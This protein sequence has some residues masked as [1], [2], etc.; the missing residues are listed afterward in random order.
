[1]NNY[2]AEKTTIFSK[3]ATWLAMP[4]TVE[5]LYAGCLA[6]DWLK[7]CAL[8]QINKFA[9]SLKMLLIG[10]GQY[11]RCKVCSTMIARGFSI[12]GSVMRFRADKGGVVVITFFDTYFWSQIY[13]AQV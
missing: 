8:T 6:A 13:S 10:P 11:L 1:M 2:H 5:S 9:F 4:H 12:H 7:Y 3:V